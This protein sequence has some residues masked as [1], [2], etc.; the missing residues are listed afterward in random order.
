MSAERCGI[1]CAALIEARL[2]QKFR[3]PRKQALQDVEVA[4]FCGEVKGMAALGILSEQIDAGLCKQ[5]IDHGQ[6]AVGSRG[7]EC[8]ALV[9]AGLVE[10]FR[11][12]GKQA[13]QDVEVAALSGAV[14]GMAA[15]GILSEQIDA[16]LCE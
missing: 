6:V 3:R 15:I 12:P 9:E 11:R 8:G 7:D 2:V 1:E 16:G 4:A 14:K 5:P 10:E 13:L